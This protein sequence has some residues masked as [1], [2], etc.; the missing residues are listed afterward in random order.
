MPHIQDDNKTSDSALA[1]NPN[2]TLININ[3]AKTAVFLE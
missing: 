2:G 3:M 1:A